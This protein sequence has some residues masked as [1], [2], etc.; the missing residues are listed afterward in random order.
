MHRRT[1][2]QDLADLRALNARFIH[3]FVAN[4]VLSHSAITH[5]RFM[6]ISPRG[7]RQGRADYLR[8]WAQGFDP[9]VIIYWDVRDEDIALFGDVALVRSANK[10][11][12]VIDGNAVTGMTAY[13]DTYI[14]E[15][16]RWLCIQAQLTPVAMENWPGDETI[17][18][19]WLRGVL[20]PRA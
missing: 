13:T 7:A 2:Q 8:D 18:N 12:R 15:G 17:L 9:E 19:T 5:P 3:N 6:C 4:D 11:V 16:D 10:W 20:Q 1:P 14:H